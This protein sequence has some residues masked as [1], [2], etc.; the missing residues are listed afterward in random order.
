MAFKELPNG[1]A[2][3]LSAGAGVCDLFAR[4]HSQGWR[5]SGESRFDF[6][7][8]IPMQVNDT[9]QVVSHQLLPPW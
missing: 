9:A 8:C 5:L 1:A 4:N 2:E 7:N 6:R 3:P